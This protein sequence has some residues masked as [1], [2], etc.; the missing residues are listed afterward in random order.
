MLDEEEFEAVVLVVDEDPG[1]RHAVCR[2]VR[3]LGYRVG[4]CEDGPEALAYLASHPG[5]VRL[6]LADLGMPGM[7]GGELLERARDLDPSVQGA[8]MVG[9]GD[10]DS[11]E[12]LTSHRGVPALGKPVGFSDLYT[13][14]REV[15]GPPPISARPDSD[16]RSLRVRPGRRTS[17]AAKP[18]EI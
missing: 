12:R 17:G 5:T 15:L 8:L 11:V 18:D 13:R 4:T 9:P 14:V 1:T 6:L 2:M 10:P 16:G 3:G 7:D